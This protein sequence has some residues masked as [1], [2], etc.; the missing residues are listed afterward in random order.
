[1]STPW[2]STHDINIITGAISN[3]SGV[4]LIMRDTWFTIA[5][6]TFEIIPNMVAA[7][8]L[9]N[10]SRTEGGA[11]IQCTAEQLP[12]ECLTYT[13]DLVWDAMFYKMTTSNLEREPLPVAFLQ[14]DLQFFVIDP[15]SW[16]ANDHMKVA[17]ASLLLSKSRG[18]LLPVMSHKSFVG[19]INT[20]L[21]LLRRR[22]F[23]IAEK[24]GCR[25]AAPQL[26]KLYSLVGAFFQR[27]CW[28]ER[29]ELDVSLL[30]ESPAIKV[31]LWLRR[32]WDLEIITISELSKYSASQLKGF[33]YPNI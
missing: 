31:Q 32:Q 12:P 27:T 1:M 17:I 28:W 2:S 7:Q 23:S 3:S 30:P 15:Q 9:A 19:R 22:G 24:W 16:T 33:S 21:S 18:T 14:E 13:L 26:G 4:V 5:H 8:I 20:L 6:G 10:S 11:F 29:I 25:T